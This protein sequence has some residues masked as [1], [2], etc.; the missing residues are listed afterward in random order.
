MIVATFYTRDRHCLALPW[1]QNRSVCMFVIS[2]V[3]FVARQRCLC[4]LH[5]RRAS[6]QA[7]P[8]FRGR[9]TSISASPYCDR[10]SRSD[11]IRQKA[12]NKDC[13][14]RNRHVPSTTDRLSTGT[15]IFPM[16][17]HI[18]YCLSQSDRT[19]RSDGIREKA[20]N[21]VCQ[22]SCAKCHQWILNGHRHLPEVESHRLVP[23]PFRS[24]Q[25]FGRYS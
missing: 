21:K 3:K 19:S 6:Q 16:S 5:V 7:P 18:N 1:G 8:S 12:K 24:D 10:T 14:N 15:V 23:L 22:S 4:K 9:N 13:A 11:I 25:P 20:K 17:K 2:M